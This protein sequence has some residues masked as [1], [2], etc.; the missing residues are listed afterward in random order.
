MAE[1]NTP[2]PFTQGGGNRESVTEFREKGAVGA[3]KVAVWEYD[4]TR[5]KEP[6]NKSEA[7]HPSG[8][9]R[10]IYHHSAGGEAA[11]HPAAADS[12]PGR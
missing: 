1:K 8:F 2:L 11:H 6:K 12:C 7:E 4:W 9:S 10:E 3:T 5:A